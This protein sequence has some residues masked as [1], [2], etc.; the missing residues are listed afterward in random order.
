MKGF[1]YQRANRVRTAAAVMLAIMLALAGWKTYAAL[2]TVRA[3]KQAEAH[4]AAGRL[5]EA[6]AQ[7][8]KASS[9]PGFD[10]HKEEISASLAELQP[11]VHTKRTV[12]SLSASIAE[13][14]ASGSVAGLAKAHADYQE[15]KQQHA[16]RG[17]PTPS[18]SHRP[19]AK[20]T[21]KR[22]SRTPSPLPAKRRRNGLRAA[23]PRTTPAARLPS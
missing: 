19:Q 22:R 12:A 23:S 6:E 15:A 3:Y 1:T 7:Y 17:Q 16:A 9:V 14:A 21:S 13:A 8:L 18:G 5:M 4:K 20:R 2:Q 10:Y 11:V